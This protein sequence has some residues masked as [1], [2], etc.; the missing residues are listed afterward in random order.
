[1][2]SSLKSQSKAPPEILLKAKRLLRELRSWNHQEH[3]PLADLEKHLTADIYM[4]TLECVLIAFE[5]VLQKSVFDL[6][7]SCK[8]RQTE[9][10]KLPL[11]FAL[12]NLRSAFNVGSVFRTADALGVEVV[13]LL[14]YTPSP[15]HKHVRETS[16]G[17][18]DHVSWRQIEHISEIP[19]SIPRASLIAV[20]TLPQAKPLAEAKLQQPSCFVFGNE[21]FG[22]NQETLQVCQQWVQIEMQGFK[23]S[24]NVAVSAA[25]VGFEWKRQWNLQP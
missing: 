25:V 9:A 21:R 15:Q 12:E 17:A 5:R 13:F 2:E 22:L 10:Q 1:L 19:K 8:D 7:V 4:H 20:E 6:P 16:M 3:A 14:G 23:N 11:Y 18:C 24:L